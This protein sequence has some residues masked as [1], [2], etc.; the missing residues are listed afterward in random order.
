MTS[1]AWTI[2]T[3]WSSQPAS[4]RPAS[5]SDFWPTIRIS[6]AVLVRIERRGNRVLVRIENP[7]VE[8]EQQRAGNRMALENI[9]ERLALF[10]D[11]EA[12]ID[13]GVIGGRFRVDIEMPYRIQAA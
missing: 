11:A 1:E 13:T 2:V 10:F 8:V 9:R 4:L 3:R 7:Y 5:I 6:S 12:R